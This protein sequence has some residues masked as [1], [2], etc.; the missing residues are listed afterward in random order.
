M[1]LCHDSRFLKRYWTKHIPNSRDE[2]HSEWEQL[3]QNL[4]VLL[5]SNWCIFPQNIDWLS[6]KKPKFSLLKLHACYSVQLCGSAFVVCKELPVP[7]VFVPRWN[8]WRLW[9]SLLKSL[10]SENAHNFIMLMLKAL[11]FS[12]A[13]Q[14]NIAN[15]S[16]KPF[17]FIQSLVWLGDHSIPQI[18]ICWS[19]GLPATTS[20]D[21]KTIA[22]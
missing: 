9:Q 2:W 13:Y 7:I 11:E 21:I 14:P 19:K 20:R 8:L 10:G 4:A 1:Y 6:S 22:Q 12:K 15:D 5:F 3:S 17:H 16:S 18:Y